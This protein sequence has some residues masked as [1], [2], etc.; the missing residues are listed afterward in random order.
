[1]AGNLSK[2]AP[3]IRAFSDLLFGTFGNKR[4]PAQGQTENHQ[5]DE[6]HPACFGHLLFNNGHAYMIA[7]RTFKSHV[8]HFYYLHY[9]YGGKLGKISFRADQNIFSGQYTPSSD[10]IVIKLTA[11]AP[12]LLKN[13]ASAFGK[14]TSPPIEINAE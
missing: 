3:T 11:N 12:I 2:P 9:F 10:T 14:R 5:E 7:K 8:F 13:M 1:M 4:D 6:D